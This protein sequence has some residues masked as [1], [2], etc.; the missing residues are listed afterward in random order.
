MDFEKVL[1]DL[2]KENA[3]PSPCYLLYGEEDYLIKD[4][5]NKIIALT[6]P[7]TDR[8]LNLF[9]MD[10]ENED[11]DGLCDNILT[12]PLLP[13]K[14]VVVLRN[15]RL[16][17]SRKVLPEILQKIRYYFEN[18]PDTAVK[19]FT[20]FMRITGW[21]LD[22]LSN[23][24]WKRITDDDWQKI[25]EGDSGQD[26]ETW[27]PG[28][29]DVCMRRGMEV[30]AKRDDTER[31][32]DIL[33][34]GIP[35]GN[36]LI[37]TAETV[38]KRK[39]LFKIISE[40]GIILHFSPVKG[41]SRQRNAFMDAARDVLAKS[42]KK[43]T[44]PAWIAIGKK[45]GFHLAD[46]MG[47]LEMLITYTGERTLIEEADVEEVVG[48][49]K[50][51]TVFDLTGALADKNL[52]KALL[53][54]Q[55]LFYQGVNHLLIMSMIAREIRFLLHAKTFIESGKIASFHQGMDYDAFHKSVYPA[56]QALMNDKGKKGSRSDFIAQHPY[57]MYHAL[58]NSHRFAYEQLVTYLEDLLDM[59]IAFKTTAK[60][61]KFLLE[62]FII[63]VCS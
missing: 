20:Q 6:I 40:T 9:F 21:T 51:D 8:D 58:K 39:R 59:D 28:I 1:I 32:E 17:Q 12:P 22:D 33:K 54:L 19:Y 3:A 44:S 50:E 15:T 36:H 35:E 24:G 7:A 57:V 53:S 56:I 4:A 48:K 52:N 13:G 11:I 42:G 62:R 49:T 55:D 45:T 26:R 23:D 34:S 46:S 10:G 18:D 41:E 27:L 14:K 43:L 38:D 31:L 37:I 25:V 2:K 16:F 30:R 61:P 60:E 47:A 5:L 29:L 63:N